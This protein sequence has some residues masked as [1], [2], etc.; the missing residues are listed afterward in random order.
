MSRAEPCIGSTGIGS[1]S[2]EVDGD[3][4]DDG[5][6]CATPRKK[7]NMYCNDAG[8]Y[9]KAKGYISNVN[10]WVAQYDKK[11]ERLAV[12]VRQRDTRRPRGT[13]SYG[14]LEANHSEK[15]IRG[16]IPVESTTHP[17]KV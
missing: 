6:D 16:Q 5:I 11:H 14:H 1:F 7:S 12:D 13:N 15:A 8:S 2:G 4:D 9:C 10:R 17:E 3:G